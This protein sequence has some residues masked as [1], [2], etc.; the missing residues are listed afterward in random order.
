MKYPFVLLAIL[1]GFT[2]C[3][4][5]FL[6]YNQSAAYRRDMENRRIQAVRQQY[7]ETRNQPVLPVLEKRYTPIVVPEHTQADGTVIEAHTEY[8][9]TIR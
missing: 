2:S 4:D 9:E 1:P 7:W 5:F 3:T 6:P 8:V